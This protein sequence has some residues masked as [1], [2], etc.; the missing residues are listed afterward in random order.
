MNET[1]PIHKAFYKRKRW[2]AVGVL[3]LVVAYPLSIGPAAYCV[4]RGWV[5]EQVVV[6]AYL[7]VLHLSSAAGML[8]EPLIDLARWSD[9][10]G[11]QHRTSE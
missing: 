11:Q 3:W 5:S 7:P 4:S 6:V 2:I 9:E 1:K 10:L 8:G